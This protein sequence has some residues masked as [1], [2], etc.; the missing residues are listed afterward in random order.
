MMDNLTF[1]LDLIA[2]RI[3]ELGIE[4]GLIFSE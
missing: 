2:A 1:Y 4:E 3:G